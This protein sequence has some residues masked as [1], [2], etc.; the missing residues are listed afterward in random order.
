M[1]IV[2]LFTLLL[3]VTAQECRVSNGVEYVKIDGNFQPDGC[4]DGLKCINKICSSVTTVTDKSYASSDDSDKNDGQRKGLPCAVIGKDARSLL[5]FIK[6]ND[7]DESKPWT[8]TSGGCGW[9]DGKNLTCV[10]DWGEKWEE[11]CPEC[12]PG[13]ALIPAS[14]SDKCKSGCT[15]TAIDDGMCNADR[16]YARGT[17]RLAGDDGIAGGALAFVITIS[18]LVAAA[19]SCWCCWLAGCCRSDEDEEV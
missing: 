10:G 6:E 16:R 3:S 13:T 4:P 12:D 15:D 17:C 9:K 18:C 2:L 14:C 7:D 8:Y 19:I 5:V 1:R 11:E